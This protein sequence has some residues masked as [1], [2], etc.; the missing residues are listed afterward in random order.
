MP[1]NGIL[2]WGFPPRT[3]LEVEVGLVR[4]TNLIPVY[5]SNKCNEN[6]YVEKFLN[7]YPGWLHDTYIK[8]NQINI[9]DLPF[10]QNSLDS[11][12]IQK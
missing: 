10:I 3:K 11:K 2:C 12:S 6:Y 8:I 7:T 9:L 1:W 5:A 4:R